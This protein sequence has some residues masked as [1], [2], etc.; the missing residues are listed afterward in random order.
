LL[1]GKVDEII[2]ELKEHFTL[3]VVEDPGVKPCRYLGGMIG[4]HI[5]EDGSS[6]WY[7]SAD[8]YLSKALPTVEAEWEEKLQKRVS[9]PLPHEYHPELDVSP[10]LS[11]AH[12]SLYASYIGILQW[13][14]ELA[15]VDLTQSVALMSRYRSAPREGHMDAVLRIFGYIK[16]HDRS[17]L[18]LDWQYKDWSNVNWSEGAD[19]KEFYPDAEE[20]LP[21]G[22]PEPLGGD[23]QLNA[24]CDA[25]H[26]TCLMTRRSTTGILIFL[27]GGPIKWYSKRQNTVESSTF[28]SEFVAMKIAVEMNDGIRYKLRMMGVPISGATNMFGDIASV[29]RNVTHPESTLNKRHNSIAYHKCRESVASGAVRVAFESG[30]ANCSDGLT[31]ALVGTPF[32][33]FCRSVLM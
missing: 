16:S 18:V 22:A 2:E 19:W 4:K 28:G 15:R 12:A 31:K 30:K 27:N 10:L 11:E 8:D 14:I 7:I 1:S 20:A 3:K 33:N 13:A 17:K 9:S 25:A 24:F 6:S 23:V 21:P 5:H 32:R 26:A 29:I